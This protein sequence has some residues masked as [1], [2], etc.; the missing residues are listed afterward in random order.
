VIYDFFKI[1]L[2]EVVPKLDADYKLS[3]F[4]TLQMAQTYITAMCELLEKGTVE[5]SFRFFDN[6]NENNNCF[7]TLNNNRKGEV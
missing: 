6:S 3:K 1:R 2:R 7:K 5:T 4:E